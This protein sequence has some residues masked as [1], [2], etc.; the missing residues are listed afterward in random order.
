MFTKELTDACIEA[1]L[2]EYKEGGELTNF[3]EIETMEIES[4]EI[5][6]SKLGELGVIEEP[7]KE[8]P[9]IIIEETNHYF[10][11]GGEITIEGDEI[12]IDATRK[13]EAE[14]ENL[15]ENQFGKTDFK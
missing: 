11:E 8:E 14:D 13:E 1:Y 9:I 15:M 5:A 7:Y 12:I 10:K 6:D 3:T 2:I 4:N